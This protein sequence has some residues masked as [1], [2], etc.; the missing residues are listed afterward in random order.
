MIHRWIFDKIKEIDDTA[1]ILLLDQGWVKHGKDMLEGDD[2]KKV[3]KDCRR[4][5]IIKRAYVS[6]Q[7]DSEQN[8]S[9][10]K[11]GSIANESKFI[12]DTLRTHFALLKMREYNPHTDWSM[13]FFLR[14]N[15]KLTLKTSLKDTIDDIVTWLD[16]DDEDTKVLLEEKYVERQS[17]KE[18]W[19]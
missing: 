7:L 18:F 1:T 2:Y 11:Y 12:F 13:G 10:L 9:Q 17:L 19:Y 4:C 8:L 3:F 15:L 6:F 5:D 14:I 16:L